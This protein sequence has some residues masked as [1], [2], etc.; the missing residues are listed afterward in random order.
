MIDVT[1]ANKID[2]AMFQARA[3]Q[4][5]QVRQLSLKGVVDTGSSHLILP[6]T[7]AKALGVPKVGEA[8]VHYG[9]HSAQTRDVVEQVE[10]QILGRKAT[11]RAIVEPNRETALIGAIVLEELDFLADCGNQRIYPRDPNR[12][13]AEV[14]IRDF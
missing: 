5:D 13:I 10:V 2:L 9:D 8:S 6:E 3:L 7:A 11:F 14:G 12:I 1:V 4:A